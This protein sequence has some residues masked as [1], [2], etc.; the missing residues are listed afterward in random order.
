MDAFIAAS[1]YMVNNGERLIGVKSMVNNGEVLGTV[2]HI[3]D[4][5]GYD[6]ACSN[7]GNASL[8]L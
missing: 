6:R 4:G 3:L 1:K 8:F 7:Y 2:E 5:I